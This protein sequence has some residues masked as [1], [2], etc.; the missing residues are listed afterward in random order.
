MPIKH[1]IWTVSDRP[2]PLPVT[3]LATAQLLEDRIENDPRN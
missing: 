2:T 3:Q 1:A